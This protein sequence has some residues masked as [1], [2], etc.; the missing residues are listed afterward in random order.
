LDSEDSPELLF[1][2]SFE[3]GT[4]TR[5]REDLIN[6]QKF[7]W[8]TYKILLDLTK[9]NSKLLS[10]YAGIL[11]SAFAF[12]KENKR[13]AE[14]KRLCDSV[15]G[16]LQTLI[17]TEKKQF[18]QNKVQISRPEVLKIL[19][20]I[21]I[22]LLDSATELEQWQE[23]FKTAEDIIF[24]MDKYERQVVEDQT[25]SGR[26]DGKS[27]KLT[28]IPPIMKLEFFS[29]IEKLLWISDYPLYHAYAT[30]LIKE[31]SAKA[32]KSLKQ[33]KTQEKLKEAKN[34][35][36]KFDLENLNNRIIL[37][38]LVTSFKNAYSNFLTVGDEFFDYENE[39]NENNRHIY[40]LDLNYTLLIKEQHPYIFDE[41]TYFR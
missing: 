12:C 25:R 10:L 26:G 9:T 14:F 5:E 16:Y 19:I 13:K 8:E 21:R 3:D 34:K 1:L 40:L 15:R 41:G 39:I 28:K 29:N 30:I 20:Q 2:F 31:L 4:D 17:K 18:F 22:N 38:A 24:L 27:K 7:I 32:Q 37:G 23:A 11:K 6:S 33:A 35:L 36:E